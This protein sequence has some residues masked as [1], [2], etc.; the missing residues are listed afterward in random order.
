MATVPAS[1]TQLE[2]A[3]RQDSLGVRTPSH[4]IRRTHSA[5]QVSADKESFPKKKKPRKKRAS[6]GQDGT[7]DAPKSTAPVDPADP[8]DP[9]NVVVKPCT[10]AKSAAAP[11]AKREVPA[12]T[13]VKEPNTQDR[14]TAEGEV[15]ESILARKS[16]EA[17]L[18]S[19]PPPG[20]ARDPLP[21]KVNSPEKSP[22]TAGLSSSDQTSVA[23]SDVGSGPGDTSG[24]KKRREKTVAEK[25]AHARFMRFTRNIQSS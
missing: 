24:R 9:Q 19:T 14:K 5:P 3:L 18:A 6:R 15:E 10:A 8:A 7:G 13:E 2:E 22:S 4:R 21:P 20:P 16:T 25:A 17:Q 12:K 11:P 23:P 1:E